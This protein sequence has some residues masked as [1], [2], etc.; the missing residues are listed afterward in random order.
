MEGAV[1]TGI[2]EESEGSL[3]LWVRP[4]I[5]FLGETFLIECVCQS[6]SLLRRLFG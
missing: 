3:K 6:L 1:G 2:S 5:V 4:E